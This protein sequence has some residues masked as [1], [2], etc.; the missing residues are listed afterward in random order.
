MLPPRA[1]SRRPTHRAPRPTHFSSLIIRT[2]ERC[3]AFIAA[4]R[5]GCFLQLIC[6]ALRAVT[7]AASA[8]TLRRG[9]MGLEGEG[10]PCCCWPAAALPAAGPGLHPRCP[11][12]PCCLQARRQGQCSD[13]GTLLL[14]RFQPPGAR[15]NVVLPCAWL[16]RSFAA[17]APAPFCTA[18]SCQPSWMPPCAAHAS[19]MP[20]VAAPI[21]PSPG[22]AGQPDD[23]QERLLG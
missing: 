4:V 20:P 11:L 7:V 12:L 10:A 23:A 5:F 1:T 16:C 17:H 18:S 22:G 8:P 9:S 2:C 19:R 13:A 14:R 21:I 6:G 15:P 3:S